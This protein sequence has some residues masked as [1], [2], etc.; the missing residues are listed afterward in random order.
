MVGCFCSISCKIDSRL[1]VDHMGCGVA[2]AEFSSSHASQDA[3][4]GVNSLGL[5]GNIYRTTVSPWRGGTPISKGSAG[6]LTSLPEAV[7]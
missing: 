1:V 6:C 7:L 3:K 5:N 2:M 4:I